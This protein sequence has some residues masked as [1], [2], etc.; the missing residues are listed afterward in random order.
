M[1]LLSRTLLAVLSL[2]LVFA[3]PAA[4]D[5]V[6]VQVPGTATFLYMEQDGMGGE[7]GMCVEGRY[8]GGTSDFDG[9]AGDEEECATRTGDT[10]LP[11]EDGGGGPSPAPCSDQASCEA[12]IEELTGGGG[13]GGAPAPCSDMDSCEAFFRAMIEEALGGP[14]GGETPAPA[15][16]CTD[17]ASCRALLEGAGG[18][19]APAPR[20]C[21]GASG[22][23]A[24]CVDFGDGNFVLGDRPDDGQGEL[25]IC[26]GGSYFYVA[27][28]AEP[29]GGAGEACPAAAPA[30]APEPK[31]APEPEP[32]QGGGGSAPPPDADSD[33]RPDSSDRCPNTVGS[34]SDGCPHND[35]GDSGNPGNSSTSPPPQS[36]PADPAE[37]PRVDVTRRRLDVSPRGR[38]AVPLACQTVRTA[39]RGVVRLTAMRRTK[40]GRRVRVVLAR[41]EFLVQ[42]GRTLERKVRLTEAGRRMLAANGRARTRARI[43][44]ASASGRV[45][46]RERVVLRRR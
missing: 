25:G 17:E 9:W 21:T 28:P 42:P 41:A 5:S 26:A 10:T 3:A 13:G 23:E 12:L 20:E 31:P 45:V 14:G 34:T 36:R 4:A 11:P 19:G 44:L 6:K 39:C 18:G 30:P 43:T 15:P 29:T 38:M 46:S 8:F 16:P 37:R 22:G 27:G 7:L 33:G 40:S 1:S 35:R 2:T 32:E 24:T